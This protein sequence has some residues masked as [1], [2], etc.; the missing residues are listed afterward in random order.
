MQDCV[1]SGSVMLILLQLFKVW[2]VMLVR[3]M[4]ESSLYPVSSIEPVL[5]LTSLSLSLIYLQT[6]LR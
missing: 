2:E 1:W 4:L 6:C 3:D 5:T